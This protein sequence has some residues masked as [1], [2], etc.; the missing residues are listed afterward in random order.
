MA[1]SPLP[2]RCGLVR[3]EIVELVRTAGAE[4]IIERALAVDNR[5]R[6]VARSGGRRLLVDE[7][8]GGGH[9]P[10]PSVNVNAVTVKLC[11]ATKDVLSTVMSPPPPVAVIDPCICWVV[12]SEA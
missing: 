9:Q 3:Y 5:Q 11:P 4:L 12:P 10:L 2:F 1:G 8:A 6:D 7:I